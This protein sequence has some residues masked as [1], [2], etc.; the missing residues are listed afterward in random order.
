MKVNEIMTTEV[1]TCGPET[2]I[3]EVASKMMELDVG[4]IPVTEDGNLRGIITDRDLV[5]R[6][7]AAQFSLDTP[8]NRILSSDN[9]TG[10]PD[11]DVEEAANIMAQQQIR[12]LPIIEDNR[13]VGIVSLGDV[14][15]DEEDPEDSEVALEEISKPAEPDK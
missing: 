13:V 4:S 5:I 8:V 10:T 15:V 1:E 3:Q 12:R 6:G 2:T 9:V 7:I 11:M 14:A